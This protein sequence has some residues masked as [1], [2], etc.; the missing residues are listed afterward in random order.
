MKNWAP[1]SGDPRCEP[2]EPL[3]SPSSDTRAGGYDAPAPR[4]TAEGSGEA[5]P[6]EAVEPALPER[7]GRYRVLGHLGKGG[8]ADVYLARRSG[9]NDLVAL[10]VLRQD[11]AREVERQVRTRFLAEERITRTI[12]H[13]AIVEIWETSAEDASPC[14]LAMDYVE[15]RSFCEHFWPDDYDVESE[16]GE[17]PGDLAKDGR[18]GRAE[19]SHWEDPRPA[20]FD[21]GSDLPDLFEV[22]RLGH[23][24]A[25]A[26]A[27]AHAKQIV[28][29]DLKPDNVLVTLSPPSGRPQVR[30]LD[31]GIAKAPLSLFAPAQAVSV[32][33]Y[34]TELG[35]VMGSPPFM[36]PE[37]NGAA[38]TVT[39]KADV[40]AL[41]AMLLVTVRHLD[42]SDLRDQ[43]DAL[44]QP[45][46]LAGFLD[47]R[48]P[49]PAAWKSL[50][51][52]L[53]TPAPETRPDMR[54][55]SRLLQRLAQKNSEFGAAVEDWLRRGRV[56]KVRR[57][58]RLLRWADQAPELTREEMQFVRQ[59]PLV[60]LERSRRR[61]AASLLGLPLAA[62]AGMVLQQG[63]N[64]LVF[65]GA[66]PAGPPSVP[67]GWAPGTWL[68]R[69]WA[70][71]DWLPKLLAPSAP[72]A[73]P[74]LPSPETTNL[75][76]EHASG[77]PGGSSGKP[78]TPARGARTNSGSGL[79]HEDEMA[80][81]KT[82]EQLAQCEKVRDAADSRLRTVEERLVSSEALKR[83]LERQ[84]ATLTS[85]VSAAEEE[86]AQARAEMAL[87]QTENTAQKQ[88]A[89][90]CQQALES[91]TQQLS[92]SMDRWRL[93]A[94]SLRQQKPPAATRRPPEHPAGS[95]A[96]TDP[97]TEGGP[98]PDFSGDDL[99][100]SG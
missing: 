79:G 19:K 61:V 5:A 51:R 49:L 35:T 47:R 20:A 26:L 34:F 40:F 36:A 64:G 41:G 17:P 54:E 73:T 55:A 65:Q 43:P 28:H 89:F 88:Q 22:A 44:T 3:Q 56:P 95:P 10:K 1:I 57:L 62:L 27:A 84:V 14:F 80:L 76:L 2:E 46:I 45:E 29:R 21:D 94:R 69:A 39:G 97:E 70:S 18:A 71:A 6:D 72:A 86:A 25:E 87:V 32:T 9:S 96:A 12:Q 33:R 58:T 77:E 37:Q 48:P 13:P 63:P 92:E 50:F 52:L 93:C 31:F 8:F 67:E 15:G 38:H 81:A 4:P 85:E 90:T 11:I 59:A 30:I 60:R 99:T 24:V 74:P 100:P 68:P 53:L 98:E 16:G 23:Q 91:K 42:E 83:E 82:R 78:S 66:P 75:D 7:I